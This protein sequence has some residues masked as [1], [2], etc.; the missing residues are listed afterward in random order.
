M[1]SSPRLLST[2]I[3]IEGQT[4]RKVSGSQSRYFLFTHGVWLSLQDTI[5]WWTI[6]WPLDTSKHYR[7][8]ARYKI[9][10]G[11]AGQYAQDWSRRW[12]CVLNYSRRL[13]AITAQEEI[14]RSWRECFYWMKNCIPISSMTFTIT[15]NVPNGKKGNLCPIRKG[16]FAIA[17]SWNQNPTKLNIRFLRVQFFW[18]S[19]LVS[20]SSGDESIMYALH[21]SFN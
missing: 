19:K 3:A 4:G 20:L 2:S 1:I 14:W 8:V 21:S 17:A 13:R 12:K 9:F 7:K 18:N 5:Y 6:S 16:S 15:S 11:K 10:I